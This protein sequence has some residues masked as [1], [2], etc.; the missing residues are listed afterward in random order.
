VISKRVDELNDD[1]DTTVRR[2]MGELDID[3]FVIKEIGVE[4]VSIKKMAFQ[5]SKEVINSIVTPH[6]SSS[7]EE[8][9]H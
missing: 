4:C 8:I 5:L 6:I 7:V 1:I 2:V 3:P 9:L